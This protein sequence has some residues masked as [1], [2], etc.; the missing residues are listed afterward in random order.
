MFRKKGENLTYVTHVDRRI[1]VVLAGKWV[2]AAPLQSYLMTID[3]QR[4]AAIK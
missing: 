1:A 4:L 2:S 3:Y